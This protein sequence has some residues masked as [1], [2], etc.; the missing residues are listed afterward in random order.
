VFSD[1][2]QDEQ[3]D[4]ATRY[5]PRPLAAAKPAPPQANAFPEGM[6]SKIEFEG[7]TTI[8]ADKIKPKLLSRVG[9][10]LDQD[11]VEADL[12][13]LMGTKWFSDIRYFVDESPSKSRNWALTFVVTEIP[14]WSKVELRGRK[15][16]SLKE[17]EDRTDLKA[18]NPVDP[19]RARLAAQQILRLYVENDFDLASVNLLRGGKPGDTE[20]V[21]EIFEGPK[22]KLNS[23]SFVGNHFASAA[24]LRTKVAA[25][26]PIHDRSGGYYSDMLDDDRQKLVDFYKSQGFFE[27]RVFPVTQPGRNPGEVDL[28]FKI[29]EGSRY[30]VRR[31]IIEG[32]TKIKTE[33]LSEGLELI[34]GEPFIKAMQEADRDRML[35]KYGEIG[36][37]DAQIT[38]EPRFTDRL[39][40]VDLVYKIEE[41][42]PLSRI[43]RNP[44]LNKSAP[45]AK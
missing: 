24:Q 2:V 35:I 19:V 5:A 9:R 31:V 21:V 20:V 37:I 23:V 17:I 18:G 7:N 27:V 45:R 41:N 14:R 4:S 30:E 6:I 42:T 25:L 40:V 29:S 1:T 3:K 44:V 15:A 12:K 22:C 11:R 10:P 8:T 32:N 39:G 28:T 33:E 36:Y 38:C 43:P 16:I 13:T 26:R 34:A